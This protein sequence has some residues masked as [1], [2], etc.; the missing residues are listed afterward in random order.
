MLRH[1]LRTGG[2]VQ[3]HQG[4]I[5]CVD[6]GRRSRDIRPNQ[7]RS[8]GFHRHLNENRRIGIGL[9]TRHFRRVDGCLYL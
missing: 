1:F 6:H 8:G 7:Q 9:F 3:A 2:A 4:D 5:E